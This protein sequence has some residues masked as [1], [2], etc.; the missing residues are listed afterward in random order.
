[1]WTKIWQWLKNL[2]CSWYSKERWTTEQM[3]SIL[4]EVITFLDADKNGN[5]SIKEI[6]DT[7]INLTK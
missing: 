3:K 4:D 2:F 6:V 5:V 7:I 1:M